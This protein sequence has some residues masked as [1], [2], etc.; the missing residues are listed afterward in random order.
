M[1]A[2]K[3]APT[4]VDIGSRLGTPIWLVNVQPGQAIDLHQGLKEPRGLEFD[5]GV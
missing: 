3:A 5:S 1:F 4:R 2:A